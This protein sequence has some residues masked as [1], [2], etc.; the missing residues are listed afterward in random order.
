MGS[1]IVGKG[2]G[3][4]VGVKL[5]D[6]VLEVVTEDSWAVDESSGM[7]FVVLPQ[8]PRTKTEAAIAVSVTNKRC[9]F[10]L[11]ISFCIVTAPT[12]KLANT[13]MSSRSNFKYFPGSGITIF[14]GYAADSWSA[15]SQI[16][17]VTSANTAYKLIFSSFPAETVT[18][19]R[20]RCQAP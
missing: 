18:F 11:K 2:V 9:F 6:S 1:S 3:V 7:L 17:G 4:I 16:R 19:I 20:D 13:L 15:N 14:M 12:G 10:I 8:A 5:T